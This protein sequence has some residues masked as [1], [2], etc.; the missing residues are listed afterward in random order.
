MMEDG[1]LAKAYGGLLKLR[2]DAKATP[3]E[4][5]DEAELSQRLTTHVER[6]FDQADLQIS[7]GNSLQGHTA[8]TVAEKEL[9][10]TPFGA[11]FTE[12]LSELKDDEDFQRELEADKDFAD[13]YG[14]YWSRPPSKWKKKITYFINN[15]EGTHA[16]RKARILS[17][18]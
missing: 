7:L 4:L 11:Q 6:I 18:Q 8:L 5:A 14:S 10:K 1:K 3:E 9:R 16:A 13:L 2:E 15:H 12:R 17:T